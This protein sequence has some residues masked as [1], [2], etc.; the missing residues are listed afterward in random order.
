MFTKLYTYAWFVGLLVAG[1]AHALLSRIAPPAA[2]FG[3]G[4]TVT[5]E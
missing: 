2:G 1:A 3:A 5:G 4:D